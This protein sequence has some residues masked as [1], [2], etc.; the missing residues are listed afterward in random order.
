[1]ELF[2][3]DLAVARD[4][5]PVFAGVSFSLTGGDALVV[6]GT[7]GAGKSTL[8]RA[9]AGL[10][11]FTGTVRFTG[12]EEFADVPMAEALHLLGHENALKPTLPLAENL[13]FWRATFGHPHLEPEEALEMV[14]LGGLGAVPFAHL[15]TGQRRRAAI[16]RLLVSWRPLW[17]L[18]EPTAGLDGASEAQFSALMAAHREDG[19]MV[20]AATHVPLDLAGASVLDMDALAR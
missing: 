10:L 7:N 19:G 11:P 2:V 8:L 3:D 15:S 17:L 9:L 14:G 13:A 1:M 20:I 16:A 5:E 12:D 4:G 6:R 18:D